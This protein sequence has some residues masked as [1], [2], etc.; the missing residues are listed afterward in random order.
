G[1]VLDV[2]EFEAYPETGG[3]YFPMAYTFSRDQFRELARTEVL[4]SV[5]LNR[6][7]WLAAPHVDAGTLEELRLFLVSAHIRHRDALHAL[8]F[9]RFS[10]PEHLQTAS[11]PGSDKSS[12]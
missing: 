5:T 10:A 8:G 11:M 9:S 12:D 4:Q 7:R 1:A 6:A 3:R 2:A